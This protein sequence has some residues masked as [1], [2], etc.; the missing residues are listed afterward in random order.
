[1]F[2]CVY[3][4][5]IAWAVISFNEIIHLGKLDFVIYPDPYP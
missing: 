1:M 3:G 4:R 5:D 2:V